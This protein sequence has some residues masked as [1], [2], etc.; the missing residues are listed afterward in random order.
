MGYTASKTKVMIGLGVSSISDSWYAFAQNVKNIEDYYQLIN[1]NIIP[2][3]R[4][5]ILTTEDLIIRQHILNLMCH[6][7]TSWMS[8]GLYFE[9]IPEILIKL[10]EMQQDGLVNIKLNQIFVT[11]KGKPFIRNICMAFDL[12][13]QRNKPETQLFSMTI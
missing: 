4:G 2:V 10:Q 1:D 3:F 12:L 8:N 9:E 7:K 6:F 11:E 13:L 5:H